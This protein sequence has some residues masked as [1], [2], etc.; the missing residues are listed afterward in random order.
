MAETN[1]QQKN[2]D[3]QTTEKVVAIDAANKRV[4]RVATEA[5]RAL[6]GKH[7]PGYRPHVFPKTKVS[8]TNA[9]KA[10][11]DARKKTDKKYKS[12]SGYPGGLKETSMRSVIE[13][14]GYTEVFRKAIKG[15]LPKNKLS[16][17]MMK[18]LTIEE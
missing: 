8:I 18:N 11:I 6:M 7:V 17:R 13:K 10:H 3:T 12:Y 2:T 4:G 9:S 14:K 5:A 1:T 16:D 15:M